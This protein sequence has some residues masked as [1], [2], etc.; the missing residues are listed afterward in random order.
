[1]KEIR[2][3]WGIEESRFLEL[4]VVR[5]QKRKK[6]KK[7]VREMPCTVTERRAWDFNS[8]IINGGKRDE[9][10]HNFEF[11]RSK[12]MPSISIELNS[13]II[14]ASRMRRLP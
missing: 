7:G 8:V 1:M 13:S 4:S 11:T 5:N 12:R 2:D 6:A 14:W 3:L 10:D 9:N